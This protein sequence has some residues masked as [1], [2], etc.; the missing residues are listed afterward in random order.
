M[1]KKYRLKINYSE[2]TEENFLHAEGIR[3]K[4]L[5]DTICTVEE[6]IIKTEAGEFYNIPKSWL[7]EIKEPLNCG[8]WLQSRYFKGV[9]IKCDTIDGAFSLQ[10]LWDAAIKNYKLSLENKKENKKSVD[11]DKEWDSYG[12]PEVVK[13]ILSEIQWNLKAACEYFHRVGFNCGRVKNEILELGQVVG[14]NRDMILVK[15]GVYEDDND[16][17]KSVLKEMGIKVEE[18]NMK[19]NKKL[20]P[21]PYSELKELVPINVHDLCLLYQSTL[22]YARG[23]K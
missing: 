12:A 14:K 13:E 23:E 16:F 15:R 11:F 5:D 2:I 7:T 8:E 17:L 6:G 21:T 20:G 19:S 10:E 4:G 22:K 18:N 3:K 1:S 9:S